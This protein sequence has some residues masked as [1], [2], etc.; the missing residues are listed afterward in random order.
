MFHWTL[1]STVIRHLHWDDEAPR[2]DPFTAMQEVN[3][4]TYT[5]RLMLTVLLFYVVAL[6]LRHSV[7]PWSGNRWINELGILYLVDWRQ[8][9]LDIYM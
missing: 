9:C 3:A 4:Q 6:S 1:V 2:L 8:G 5:I 7:C